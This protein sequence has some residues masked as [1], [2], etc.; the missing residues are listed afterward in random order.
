MLT[1]HQFLAEDIP[2]KGTHGFLTRANHG[3]WLARV[4]S[5]W[6]VREG[7]EISQNQE[8]NAKQNS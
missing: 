5:L 3:T 6:L 1:I 8:R 2:C 4:N 7:R